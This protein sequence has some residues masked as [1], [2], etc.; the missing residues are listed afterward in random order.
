MKISTSKTACKKLG[1]GDDKHT[2]S[3]ESGC[4][5]TDPGCCTISLS[6]RT[7]SSFVMFSKLMSFTLSE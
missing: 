1:H 3:Y 4:E 6:V 5:F 7:A 2:C